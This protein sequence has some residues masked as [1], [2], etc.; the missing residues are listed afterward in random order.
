MKNKSVTMLQNSKKGAFLMGR[1]YMPTAYKMR[2]DGCT[3]E[4]IARYFGVT[5]QRIHALFVQNEQK[6]LKKRK[7]GSSI[8]KE[9]PFKG[10]RLWFETDEKLTVP[11]IARIMYGNSDKTKS[12]KVSRLI[13]GEN[14]MI[15]INQLNNLLSA[16]GMTYEQ[17]FERM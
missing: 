5:K 2:E 17:L 11:V 3:Y 13:K 9:V 16:S 4:Q 10:F 15:T 8:Y 1:V 7:R 12:N 14:V 6:G